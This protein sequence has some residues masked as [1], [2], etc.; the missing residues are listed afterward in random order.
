MNVSERSVKSAKKVLV[1]GTPDLVRAVEEGRV[2]VSSAARIAEL[3]EAEQVA[4]AKAERPQAELKKRQR[5]RREQALAD[6]SVAKGVEAGGKTYGVIYADPP[7][8]FETY[9]EAG[10]GRSAENH[11]PTMTVADI[12][13]IE[14]PAAADSVL[15]LWATVPM[16][17]EALQ[18][19]AAW[20]FEYKSHL[21]WVKDR[22][23]TGYWA[24]NRHELLLIGTK[25]RM[26]APALGEQGASVIEAPV[27]RHSEKPPAFAELI[28]RLFPASS[29]L[30]MFCRKPRQGWDTAGNEVE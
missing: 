16:L 15:Y 11:Y 22:A 24:R 4:V 14:V 18:V 30:E 5:A 21:V 10:K 3:E 20:G 23:G 1:S 12:C 2:S 19:M 29:K 13:G 6:K 25:G 26:P 17:P 9:S 27:G 8:R 7:W 28:E